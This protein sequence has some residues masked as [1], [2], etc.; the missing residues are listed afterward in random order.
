MVVHALETYHVV[1]L[2]A[3]I[4]YRDKHYLSASPHKRFLVIE[5]RL[6]M[7]A[8]FPWLHPYRPQYSLFSVMT[9]YQLLSFYILQSV[10]PAKYLTDKTIYHIQP[11]GSFVVGG[12]QVSILS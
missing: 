10:I 4:S 11:S 6:F 9:L 12:P 2:I 8:S 7:S 1:C 5:Y 3:L